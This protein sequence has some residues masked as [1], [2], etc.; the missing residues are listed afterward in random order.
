MI[1]RCM[2]ITLILKPNAVNAVRVALIFADARCGRIRRC[3]TVVRGKSAR[4]TSRG[5]FSTQKLILSK[6]VG[7]ALFLGAVLFATSA[8]A[9]A[10]PS[11]V[12]DESGRIID[13][14][15]GA[16]GIVGL[17][18]SPEIPLGSIILRQEFP[19][20]PLGG[21]P[22]QERAPGGRGCDKKIDLTNQVGVVTV[23][24]QDNPICIS[25][26]IDTYVETIGTTWIVQAGGEEAAFILA[27]VT[28]PT[29][30]VMYGPFVWTDSNGN[31]L[32]NAYTPDAKAFKQG[33]TM[34][35]FPRGGSVSLMPPAVSSSS[36]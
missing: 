24:V 26:D 2:E 14:P 34:W 5:M 16:K 12:P 28:E 20:H 27:D 6:G 18:R 11:A 7:S 29:S 35:P 33:D 1:I 25:A 3:S 21:P 10:G 30:P 15:S 19:D 9:Q 22:G 36:T 23:A 8:L 31:Q 32:S 4:S 17:R 13:L